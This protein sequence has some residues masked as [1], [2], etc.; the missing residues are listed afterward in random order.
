M[1]AK[2]LWA[3]IEA[4][5]PQVAYATF[6]PLLVD[7][8]LQAERST[9]QYDRR[10]AFYTTYAWAVPTP[11]AM[12][13]I[14]AAVGDRKLLEV[15]AGNGL[16]ARLLAEAGVEVIATDG[17][18]P[19]Q[20]WYPVEV[21][22]ATAAVDGHPDCRALFLSWPPFR[23]TSAYLA[24]ERFK[25][26]L[27]VTAGDPSFT[28]DADFHTMLTER[29]TLIDEVAL[30]SWPGTADAVRIYAQSHLSGGGEG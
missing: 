14:A 19:T 2:D 12:E 9:A 11:T 23:H 20:P 24:L 22:E 8:V 29:W 21:L 16:W 10:R 1:E 30:P 15:F 5:G 25:G 17:V 6:D 27:V 18:A 4:A 28:A 13:R 3:A 26:D 7:D